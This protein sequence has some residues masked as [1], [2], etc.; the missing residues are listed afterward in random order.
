MLRLEVV[1]A[2][3]DDVELIDLAGDFAL[4]V[5]ALA[6]EEIELLGEAVELLADGFEGLVEAGLALLLG[7]ALWVLNTIFY[8]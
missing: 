6:A 3:A 4:K 1:E 7:G 2:L 8:T 5:V